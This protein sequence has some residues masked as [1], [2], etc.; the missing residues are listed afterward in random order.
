MLKISPFSGFTYKPKVKNIKMTNNCRL[1]SYSSLGLNKS[2]FAL[3]SDVFEFVGKCLD[4]I[5]K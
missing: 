3:V 2:G 4:K 1:F 5:R